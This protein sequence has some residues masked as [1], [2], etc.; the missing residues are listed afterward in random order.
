MQQAK[1]PDNP[2]ILND[3]L[4]FLSIVKGRSPRT[5]AEYNLDLRLFLKYIKFMK[6]E[7]NQPAVEDMD[8]RDVDIT[9]LRQ[10]T[11]QDIYQFEYYLQDDRQNRDRARS[12][13]TS[14]VKGFF[15]YLTYN[16]SL[17]E[18]NPA[19]HL[20]LPGIKHSL[21]KFL[22]LEESLRM[23]SSVESDHPQRDY[24][25][26]VL[27][28][29][30]G[31]RLSELVGINVQDVDM[32]ERRLRILGKGNKE[33]MIYLND[34]CLS[35]ITEYLQTRKN[36]PTE[37]NALFLSRNN[38]RISRRRVQQIVESVLKNADLGG[39][40]LSAH[41]LRHTAAT[42]MYQHG[43]VDTLTLKEILGH[44]SIATTEIYTHLSDEQRQDA[45]EHN[46]LANV[47]NP[48]KGK[49]PKE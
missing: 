38:R 24:C 28:L 30:C 27:F 45:I 39:R 35:A 32:Y 1:S 9:L 17:L 13:K 48:Y 42:L 12:R 14:A 8:I 25:I 29:N 37:P 16:M 19:E 7:H 49:P 47:K 21:P 26:L 23:L 3:Y 4:I 40:G 10:V 5:V 43:N 36:P 41:K 46:P 31:I 2:E 15:S 18:K 44:K 33:R 34:A 11:L 6:T 22:S 20:E